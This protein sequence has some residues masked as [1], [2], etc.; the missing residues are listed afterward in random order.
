[1][2]R[3]VEWLKSLRNVAFIYK[4]GKQRLLLSTQQSFLRHPVTR[5]RKIFQ[6]ASSALEGR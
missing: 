1:M 2:I 6:A 5:K 4:S 3:R